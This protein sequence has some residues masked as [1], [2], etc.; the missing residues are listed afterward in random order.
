MGLRNTCL[1]F[2]YKMPGKAILTTPLGIIL[3]KSLGFSTQDAG[4]S[5]PG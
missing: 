1:I 3:G 2:G 4:S 5:P